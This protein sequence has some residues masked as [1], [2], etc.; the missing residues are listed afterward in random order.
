MLMC[1]QIGR[2]YLI[3]IEMY[4]GLIAA[5]A[6]TAATATN[7]TASSLRIRGLFIFIGDINRII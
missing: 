7:T 3:Q 6:T 5:I 1:V 4:V 2:H